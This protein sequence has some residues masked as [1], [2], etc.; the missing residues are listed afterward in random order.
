MRS[1]PLGARQVLV[2]ALEGLTHSEIGDVL[3]L[4]ENVVSVRL[5]RAR[6]ALRAHLDDVANE[7][8]ERHG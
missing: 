1:L 7:T 4:A 3:G 5:H 8:G 2:L 6:V